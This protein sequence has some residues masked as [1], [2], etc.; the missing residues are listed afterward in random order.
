MCRIRIRVKGTI[1]KAVR[2]AWGFGA[3]KK[4]KGIKTHRLK[5]NVVFI[6]PCPGIYRVNSWEYSMNGTEA[7]VHYN[8]TFL[9]GHKLTTENSAL[10]K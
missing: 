4:Q 9:S 6:D 2:R 10:L 1:Y 5:S 8:V 3:L 7:K